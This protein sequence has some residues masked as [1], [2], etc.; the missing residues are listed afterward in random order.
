[1]RIVSLHPFTTDI[2]DYCGIGWNLVGVTHVCSMPKNSAKAKELVATKGF[3]IMDALSEVA[4]NDPIMM[5]GLVR[6][7]LSGGR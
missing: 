3:H 6:K 4:Y 7:E 1:M 5:R 2:L